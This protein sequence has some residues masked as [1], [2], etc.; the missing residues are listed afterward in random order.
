MKRKGKIFESMTGVSMPLDYIQR[1]KKGKEG[2]SE[3]NQTDLENSK[4]SYWQL[5]FSQSKANG[6][7]YH[8]ELLPGRN[9]DWPRDTY[10]QRR[11][12]EVRFFQPSDGSKMN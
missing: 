5:V 12:Q 1:L 3:M 9:W 7:P 8:G 10:L 4:P 11:L 6:A 2:G